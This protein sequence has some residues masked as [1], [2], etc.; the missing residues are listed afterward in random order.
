MPRWFVG[1]KMLCITIGLM[2]IA[3]TG[4]VWG[5]ETRG[6]INVTVLDPQQA[7]VQDATLELVDLA[8]NETRTAATQTAG[9][10]GF[11]NLQPGKYRLTVSKQG[12][13]NTVY[14][15][16]TVEATKVTD[17]QTVLQ[18]GSP[19][20]SV[21]VEAVAPVV[22][23]T[24]VAI[25]SVIDMKHIEGLPIVGR[26]ISQLSRIVPGYTGT[27]NGLPAIAQGNNVDGVIS[28]TS[29][30]KFGGNSA[31]S[32]NVR[33]ENIEEM[34]VQTDQLDMNQGFGMAAMQSNYITRRG[35]NAFHGNVF[36]DIRNDNLN[37]NSWSNNTRGVKRAEFKLNEFGG[38][39]GGP[40]LKDTLFFF[41]S[42]S[43][44][45][46]P[47]AST[48]N[49]TFLTPSAQGGNFTY[50]G[51]DGQSHTVNVYTVAKN[52]NATLPG[53]MNSVIATEMAR[54]NQAVTQGSITTTT[55]PI[56]NNVS[57]TSPNPQTSWFPTFRVD[58]TPSATWRINLA[59]NQTKTK[60][61]TSGSPYFP[62][63]YFE[64]VAGGTKSNRIS[65]SLGIDWTATNTL[66]N[67]FRF[68]FLYPPSWNPYGEGEGY[69]GWRNYPQTVGWNIVTSPMNWQYPI[70]NY[71][72]VF[73]LAD[74]VSWQ[75]GSHTLNFGFSAYRENDKYWNR[76]EPTVVSLGL[77]T[78]DP[79]LD[80]LT[81]AGSYQPLPFASTSQQAEARN[82]YALLTG[83][84]SYY[85]GMYPY[86]P[87][88][89]NYVQERLRH[90]DLNEVAKAGGF[91]VQDSW[92]LRPNLTVNLGFRWDFT[93]AS[94]DKQGAYHNADLS[95]IYGPSGIGNLFKPGTLTGNMNPTLEERPSPYNPW[96]ITPQPALGLAWSPRYDDGFLRKIF[97]N[98]DTVI[99]T[100]FSL[101]NFT[102]P[103]QYFW[104]NATNY[105]GF[106][107]QFYTATARNV[108]G[109]GSFAPGSISLGD[110]YP[111]FAL[112]PAKYEQS[113]P[114][115]T[116]T[117]NNNQ[118]TN[119]INGMD[120]DL[121]QPYTMTWTFGIQRSL[122][123]SR[124]LEIRYN[125]NRTIKQWLSLNLN[126]VNVFENG[127]LQE[128]KNAQKN[129]AINGGSSFANLDPTK[130]TVPVPILTAAFTG[131]KDGSQTSS[132]FRR[133][134]FITQLNTGAVGS[135]AQTLTTLGAVPYFC[136]LVGA[137]FTPCATNAG[138]TGAGGGYPINFFQANPYA[139]GIPATVMTDPGYS[140]YH[141][142]QIDFRQRFWHGLQFNANY[143][144][145]HTLGVATPND[146]TGAYTTYTLRNLHESY[147][148]TNYD[149]RHVANVS[150]TVDLPFGA[151]KMWMNQG[152]AINKVVGGWTVGTIMTYR[153]GNA[154]R[155]TGG[156]NT[157][158]NLADGGVNL[159]GIGREQL[160][161]SVGVYRT[162][163]NYITMIDPKYRT[164]GVGANTAYITANTTPGTYVGAF[165]LYGPGSWE[166]DLSLT[167]DTY[168][169][170][171]QRII[172]QAQFLNAF[173]HP[174][175]RGA[176]GGSVRSSG[177]GTVT[178]PSNG[179]RVIE[180]RLRFAF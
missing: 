18:I 111:E 162:G 124:A 82:L 73:T 65:S 9:N 173:N 66:L 70:S 99:R 32:V 125:G 138:Y 51:T 29:R 83:R 84:T 115:A 159:S 62:G 42:L 135:M 2:I 10:Y 23:A 105:G 4:P 108:P 72:P 112:N 36:W 130:G 68:G 44:A 141:A 169:T 100:S 157:F 33:L 77:V 150:G 38:S 106:Y 129:L 6:R 116:F 25:S 174:V 35:T 155:V 128:F 69:E 26:D 113:T 163:A 15:V 143:T 139:S 31:P 165:Y 14:D 78:G 109:A 16:V 133:G 167:K 104:N 71:Y 64:Q 151:G 93:A 48:R 17:I 91:F 8:T 168:I 81:N 114:A 13:R 86:E 87:E 140:N 5:Q 121:S 46:Q 175:F 97:G 177:W 127:F 94:Y 28:S 37:A 63:E 92:R 132:E 12:F 164:V 142:M 148:P 11:I 119:G 146:W 126:E 3:L 145:S 107:Y 98:Q 102:V 57:W 158:N 55:D 43:T 136:N 118:F 76:P 123:Q 134:T 144:W 171:R 172:F 75:K 50:T 176:P 178:G 47:G 27:W 45:R 79:A 179:A 24:S 120:Y 90:F 166:A 80:A 147:G 88:T 59:V 156:Y 85:T 74:S 58:Y 41:F 52:F 21:T 161:A 67:S 101:R 40:I 122:G 53:T 95:S 22:E 96:Y 160:Q 180:F 1:R 152:G 60:A 49:S 170:E 153:T 149:I 54:I 137:S 7:V 131:S 61:P 19:T 34:T 56:I 39:V 154:S 110:P 20:E 89:G 103:Y 30:M 117:F